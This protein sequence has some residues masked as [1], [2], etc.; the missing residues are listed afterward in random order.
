MSGFTA[1]VDERLI[2]VKKVFVFKNIIQFMTAEVII[3]NY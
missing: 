3:R 1:F 2:P